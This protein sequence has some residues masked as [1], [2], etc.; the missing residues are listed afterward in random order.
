RRPRLIAA[1]LVNLTGRIRR[2]RLLSVQPGSSSLAHATLHFL[3][4]LKL[5]PR[6]LLCRRRRPRLIGAVLVNLTGRI[7]RFRLLSVQPRSSSLAHTTLSLLRRLRFWPRLLLCR[8]CTRG[9][10]N[11]SLEISRGLIA[12]SRVL[13]SG[14]WNSGWR[15]FGRRGRNGSRT[16]CRGS[17]C[18]NVLVV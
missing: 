15:R 5:W 11:M 12:R 18:G 3:W 9:L 17:R 13:F 16:G 4:R 2:F 7:R 1:V 10:A 6:L 14:R 8:G